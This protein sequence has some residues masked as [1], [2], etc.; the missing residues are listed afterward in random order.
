MTAHGL[1]MSAPVI[2]QFDAGF[3][4]ARRASICALPAVAA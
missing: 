3:I 2:A 4:N 1:V